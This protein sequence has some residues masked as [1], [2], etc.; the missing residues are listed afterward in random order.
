MSC[1]VPGCPNNQKNQMKKPY[2]DRVG[3]YRVR[4]G[5]KNMINKIR[6]DPLPKKALVCGKHFSSECFEI[7]NG[8][9]IWITFF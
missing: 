5:W 4:G 2:K 9:Y 3:F 8:R 1:V 7:K 6:N